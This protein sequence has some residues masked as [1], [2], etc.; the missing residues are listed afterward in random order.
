VAQAHRSISPSNKTRELSSARRSDD[1]LFQR[2]KSIETLLP[3]L[4]LEA[5]RPVAL[6][7]LLG[8]DAAGLSA[9]A[10]GRLKKGWLDEYAAWQKCDLSAKRYVQFWADGIH[11]EARLESEKQCI[12]ADRRD[13]ERR[14]LDVQ[15]QPVR[16]QSTETIS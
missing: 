12:G 10:V 4:C 1:G 5:F 11:L 16:I 9:S 13:L 15:P 14:G 2:S 6:A 7:A 3:I 8:K